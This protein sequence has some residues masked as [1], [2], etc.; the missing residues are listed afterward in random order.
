MDGLPG[1]SLH[2]DLLFGGDRYVAMPV[3]HIYLVSNYKQNLAK[4]KYHVA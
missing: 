4:S 1:V 3:G 2:L